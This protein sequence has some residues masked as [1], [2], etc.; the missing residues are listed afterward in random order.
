MNSN[1]YIA[2]AV[3]FMLLTAWMLKSFVPGIIWGAVFAISLW[4]LFERVAEKISSNSTHQALLFSFV[5]AIVFVLPLAYIAYDIADAYR[6]GSTF[7]AKNDEGIVPVP[8]F[9]EHLPYASKLNALWS[10]NVGH[11][12]G[13][14]DLLNQMSG[15]QLKNWLSVAAFQISS[16]VVTALC[17]LVSLYF[18][19][20]NG[21]YIKAHYKR[22][23]RHWFSEKGIDV[24]NKGVAALRG[25]INGV[26]LVGL[27]EGV[28]LA[29][30]LVLAG[31]K[32]G[33]LLGLTAGLLG[34][35]PLVMPAIILPI[36][37]YLYFSGDVIYAVVM[38]V[39]LLLVWIVFENVVKP[40]L[41]GNAVKV[42]PYLV[43]LG[44]I[45]GLQLFGPVGLFIGPA[46]VSMSVAMSKDIWIAGDATA[47]DG[48]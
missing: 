19:L 23:V 18:M 17:M 14:I 31:V 12:E 46:I 7:L 10:E 39:D 20:K 36:I 16:G 1:R 22:T 32:S 42:S 13:P 6:T 47:D 27:V 2:F 8:A 9:V 48:S 25:T 43:L 37:F 11:S 15:N 30:P 45:G 40:G 38:A 28:L 4:P 35:I 26:I 34:I 5:F 21:K 33:L 44:L 3:A 24:L 29:V 41:I